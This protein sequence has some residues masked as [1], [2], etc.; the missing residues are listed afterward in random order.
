MELVRS[1]A[2]SNYLEVSQDSNEGKRSMEKRYE[3]RLRNWSENICEGENKDSIEVVDNVSWLCT[4]TFRG[5]SL[6]FLKDQGP[7]L[8]A[9]FISLSSGLDCLLHKVSSG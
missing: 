1:Y 2:D 9:T 6:R 8:C 4:V 5:Y 3:V 7:T